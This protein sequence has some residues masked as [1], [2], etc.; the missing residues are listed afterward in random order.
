MRQAESSPKLFI[1]RCSP[2]A[3][4]LEPLEPYIIGRVQPTECQASQPPVAPQP[5]PASVAPAPQPGP[6]PVL[7]ESLQ[8]RWSLKEATWRNAIYDINIIWSCGLLC[9]API[10]AFDGDPSKQARALGGLP[11]SSRNLAGSARIQPYATP[12]NSRCS[13]SVPGPQLSFPKPQKASINWKPRL[14]REVPLPWHTVQ[15]G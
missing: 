12:P 14:G 10:R 5:S 4:L 1:P 7:S 3:L 2:T 6:S 15:A 13:A 11:V 8:S 9:V